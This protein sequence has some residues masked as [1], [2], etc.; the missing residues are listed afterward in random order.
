STQG[1][2]VGE[3]Q[4]HRETLGARDP[5]CA[6]QN[7]LAKSVVLFGQLSPGLVVPLRGH[8]RAL[9]RKLDVS[10]TVQATRHRQCGPPRLVPAPPGGVVT[11]SIASC[12][13]DD[14]RTKVPFSTRAK[15]LVSA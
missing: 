4:S 5:M 15:V 2:V 14:N 6:G 11:A 1:L 3:A 8:R 12:G 7:P 10:S 13:H 9:E